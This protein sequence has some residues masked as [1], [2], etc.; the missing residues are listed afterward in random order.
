L[1][2]NIR[3]GER[4][5]G[6]YGVSLPPR[7]RVRILGKGEK[8]EKNRVV[9]CGGATW[10][11]QK[12]WL[13]RGEKKRGDRLGKSKRLSAPDVASLKFIRKKKG[14]RDGSPYGKLAGIFSPPWREKRPR[15]TWR[16][17]E[18]APPP[19]KIR[20]YEKCLAKRKEKEDDVCAENHLSYRARAIP[21][22][23]GESTSLG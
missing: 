18:W 11:P 10:P 21:T 20:P 17:R 6:R 19:Q 12:G 16:K 15:S 2:E 1:K 14:R 13:K 5:K 3:R 8:K 23:E 22:L 7:G 4:P 9:L